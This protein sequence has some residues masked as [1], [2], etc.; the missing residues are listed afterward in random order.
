MITHTPINSIASASTSPDC[1]RTH[2]LRRGEKTKG[3]GFSSSSCGARTRATARLLDQADQ[4]ISEGA[5]GP[6]VEL[7][8][9][10]TVKSHPDP[11]APVGRCSSPFPCS[12]ARAARGP[13]AASFFCLLGNAR[14]K[15]RSRC[16]WPPPLLSD[17]RWRSCSS[18]DPISR[19]YY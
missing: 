18:P 19:T 17:S 1:N 6:A 11:V 10:G 12:T 8:H 3:G 7:R 5:V 2:V 13:M 9:L 16:A 15:S 14:A 4:T